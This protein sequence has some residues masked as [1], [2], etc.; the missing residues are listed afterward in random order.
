MNQSML[1]SSQGLTAFSMNLKNQNSATKPDPQRTG[2]AGGSILLP[3]TSHDY[4][5]LNPQTPTLVKG[6]NKYADRDFNLGKGN[7]DYVKNLLR[8]NNSFMKGLGSFDKMK[9]PRGNNGPQF[10]QSKLGM[11]SNQSSYSG[12]DSSQSM[13]GGLASRF[14]LA[15]SRV[16]DP[17]AESSMTGATATEGDDDIQEIRQLIEEM[18]QHSDLTVK[19]SN[20]A[21]LCKIFTKGGG[22]SKNTS[23]MKRKLEENLKNLDPEIKKIFNDCRIELEALQQQKELAIDEFIEQQTENKIV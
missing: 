18:N 11:G 1:Q 6:K 5:T 15:L 12:R 20:Q 4:S 2:R 23:L 3:S 9:S 17:T 16:I 8:Q 10:G 19:L 7:S 21:K 13:G 14:Q 22:P